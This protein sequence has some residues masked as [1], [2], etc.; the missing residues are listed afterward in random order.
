[1]IGAVEVDIPLDLQVEDREHAVIAI[2]IHAPTR[3]TNAKL[4]D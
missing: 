4:R 3:A 2:A 1:M